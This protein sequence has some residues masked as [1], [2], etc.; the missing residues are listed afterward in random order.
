MSS[1]IITAPMTVS[2]SVEAGSFTM[3]RGTWSASAPLACLPG[4]ITLYRG[5]RDRSGGRFRRFY[6]RDVQALEAAR[7]EVK[8]MKW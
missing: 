1:T 8:G 7:E 2:V 5:L 4:W 6:E 3:S